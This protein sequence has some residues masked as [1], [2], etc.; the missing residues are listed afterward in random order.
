MPSQLSDGPWTLPKV[1]TCRQP[2]VYFSCLCSWL[3]QSP[4]F[5]PPLLAVNDPP[6]LPSIW[7]IV[8][9][10]F[11]ASPLTPKGRQLKSCHLDILT[12]VYWMSGPVP[13]FITSIPHPNST[14]EVLLAPFHRRVWRS[15][16]LGWGQ[17][18]LW[19]GLGSELV[20]PV[21]RAM[22]HLF[23]LTSMFTWGEKPPFP[24]NSEAAKAWGRERGS[25]WS[26]NVPRWS[27]VR[28]IWGNIC[29]LGS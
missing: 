28:D 10:Q 29:L 19:W 8:Q 2:V 23:D 5:P 24:S 9:T 25:G 3:S 1:I 12:T 4:N 7:F 14:K 16:L 17:C 18:W 13:L 6:T 26:L 20:G 27:S 11:E 22:C 21:S 15:Y